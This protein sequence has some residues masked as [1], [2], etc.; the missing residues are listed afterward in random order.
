VNF[1][2]S[3]FENGLDR[4]LASGWSLF[5]SS[6]QICAGAQN[7]RYCHFTLCF[8]KF[9]SLYVK[10]SYNKAGVLLDDTVSKKYIKVVKDNYPEAF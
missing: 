4:L 6:S 5:Y 8:V 1:L 2:G 10:T 7:S 9:P 3:Q